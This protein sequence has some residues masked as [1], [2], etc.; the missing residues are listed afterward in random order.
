M[1][2][3]RKKIIS[4]GAGILLSIYSIN[5]YAEIAKGFI[6]SYRDTNVNEFSP[7][8]GNRYVSRSILNQQDDPDINTAC[9]AMSF[10]ILENYFASQ[11]RSWRSFY[12][13]SGN[14]KRRESSVRYS[15]RSIKD[16]LRRIYEYNGLTLKSGVMISTNHTKRHL[17]KYALP[18]K[19]WEG[20]VQSVGKTKHH[21]KTKEQLY[22]DFIIEKLKGDRPSIVLLKPNSSL[23]PDINYQHFIVI[24]RADDH[25]IGY[26]DPWK[27]EMR[28][29]R[30][31]DFFNSWVHTGITVNFNPD[32]S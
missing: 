17:R 31:R 20:S 3:L 29:A 32:P 27:G 26:A 9:G 22:N 18:V 2:N 13:P 4:V 6:S 21:Y 25:I 30:K 5:T 15:R 11:N 10:L 23:M 8:S 24:F 12:I 14:S 7:T 28:Y 19:G 1:K 16:A